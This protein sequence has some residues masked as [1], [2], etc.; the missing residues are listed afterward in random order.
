MA[1]I[2]IISGNLR[3]WVKNSG[4]KERTATLAEAVVEA[5]HDVTFL[6]FNWYGPAINEK[7]NNGIH[8]IQPEI[9]NNTKRQRKRLIMDEAKEN[10]DIVFEILKDD[11]FD[12]SKKAEK[13]ARDKDL[14]I[15]DHYSVAPLIA[16]IKDIPI[17]YSSHNAELSMAKQLTPNNKQILENV[18]AMERLAINKSYAIIYC[19]KLDNEELKQT[20]NFSVPT[21]YI[22]NGAVVKKEINYRERFN[23]KDIIFVGSGHP[24]N[25]IAADRV[26]SISK[27]CPEY[28]FIIIGGCGDSISKNNLPENIKILGHVDEDVLDQYFKKSFAFIN[29][30]SSGSG[31][32]L[33]MMKAMSYGIPI[34]TSSI[35]ARGYEKQEISDAMIVTETDRDY[36][37]AID[38]LNNERK[39][40]NFVEN[41]YHYAKNYDWQSIK[42]TYN[43]V[44]NKM[45]VNSLVKETAEESHKREKVLIYS[46]IRNDESHMD[47]YYLRIKKMLKSFPEYEFYLSLYE[48]DSVDATKQKLFSND[49]SMFSKVSIISENIGTK[50]YGPTKDADRVKNLANARN[51]ALLANDFINEVDYVLMIDIDM[52]FD[53]DAAKQLLSFKNVEPN[54]D[55]VSGTSIR[56]GQLYDSWATRESAEYNPKTKKLFDDYRK[57]KYKKYYSTSN[58]FC[59]YRAKPFKDGIR[60]GYINKVTSEPDCEMVVVCQDFHKAGYKNIYIIHDALVYHEH[61]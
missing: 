36:R 13:I 61:R 33:K 32:H 4:G 11:L 18:E 40:K 55:I 10:W 46:I 38:L 26:V 50:F 42:K 7:L 41:L 8:F 58:G 39:Y 56:A 19:S 34:I 29:P 9:T 53:M 5:G 52:K 3:D 14:I 21:H 30:M 51:K 27:L 1:K 59:L 20:Y 45:L 49:L 25:R 48:N 54:F 2:L 31:T 15:L 12:F 35:G 23:S 37:N 44:I 24:P 16:N 22:P 47:D 28:N 60:Y 17:I 6:S 57:E 43:G